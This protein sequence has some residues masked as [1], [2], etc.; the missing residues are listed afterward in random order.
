MRYIE[1]DGER[2]NVSCCDDCPCY[3]GGLDAGCGDL[4]KHPLGDEKV[5]VTG[6]PDGMIERNMRFFGMMK[7]PWNIATVPTAH[8]G[9]SDDEY[10]ICGVQGW[11]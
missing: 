6:V 1:I 4:C 9:R 5:A 2:Y 3:D 7:F 8:L 11:C 10:G